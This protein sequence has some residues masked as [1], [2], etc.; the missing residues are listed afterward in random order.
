MAINIIRL[1]DVII[2]FKYY[3]SK[4]NLFVPKAFQVFYLIIQIT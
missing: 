3:S 1:K 4:T 2:I